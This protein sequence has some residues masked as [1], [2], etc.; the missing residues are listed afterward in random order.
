MAMRVLLVA[1]LFSMSMAQ[2]VSTI[3]GRVT[4]AGSGRALPRI[5]VTLVAVDGTSLAET[6]TDAEGRYRFDGVPAG[7]YAVSASPGPHRSDLLRQWFG[8]N[9][10]ASRW[11]RPRRH[12]IE[13]GAARD[14][15]DVDIAMVVA[16]AIEGRI[17][18]PWEEGMANVAVV[19]MRSDGRQASDNPVYSDDAGVYRVFGL[20]PGRYQVCATPRQPTQSD[21]TPATPFVRTCHPAA[22]SESAAAE[23]TLTSSDVTEVDVRVQRTG[24]RT[25][26]G[27]VVDARG[28]TA[29]GASVL[30]IATDR[31]NRTADA[32]VRDGAFSIAGLVPGR[33][34]VRVFIGGSH[35]GDPNPPS[36]PREM[37]FAQLDLTSADVNAVFT[38]SA[39]R[40][41]RGRIVFEGEPASSLT[42]RMTVRAHPRDSRSMMFLNSY[43]TAPVRDDATFELPEI[44]T[45]PLLVKV[46]GLPDEWKVRQVRHDGR[47]VTY[48][49]TD[50]SESRKPIEV[51]VT[52]RLARPAVR[53]VDDQRRG[54]EGAHVI[55]LVTAGTPSLAGVVATSERSGTDGTVTLGP[56]PPGDYRFIA[57]TNDDLNLLFFDPDRF[58]SLDGIGTLATLR[59]SD[60][61]RLALRLARLPEKR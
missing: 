44:Y 1:L 30:A 50:F 32:T 3:S 18:S 51:V 38:L 56:L 36:R 47:D 34:F 58:A 60:A 8:E 20:A 29:D 59:E 26:S 24:G 14:L 31:G 13:I 28:L 17:L 9:E 41:V 15:R 11:G 49:A 27:T 23:V 25:L 10:P 54:V 35:R 5:V 46:E 4:E 43:P 12:P 19:A 16:L 37:A 48:V 57:L 45:L 55:A 6:L 33:Y 2:A 40:T 53:V 52:N 42:N 61:P 22:T 7:R 21:G 39:A